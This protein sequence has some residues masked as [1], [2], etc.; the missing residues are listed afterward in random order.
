MLAA[1]P[2]PDPTE[3]SDAERV[4]DRLDP[5]SARI[6]RAIGL[7][8][9]SIAETSAALEHVGD[10]GAGGAAPGA[11]EARAAAREDG[12]MRTEQL[13]QAM[14]A[15]TERAAAAEARLPAALALATAAAGGLFLLLAGARPDLAEALGRLPVIV[16]Q[17]FPP[18]LAVGAFGA[19]LR[20]AR[21]GARVGGWA[22]A[23]LAVPV[24]LAAAV[25]ASSRRMPPAGWGAAMIGHSRNDCLVA[26]PLMSMPGLARRAVGAA[27]RGEHAARAHRGDGGPDERRGGGV[28]L[29]LLLQRRQSAFLGV[30]YVLAIL[31]VAG[32]GAVLGRLVL[33]W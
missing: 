5:R 14:A 10:G 24:L 17:L 26:I 9:A 19:A 29:R 20:L 31:I 2:E 22:L 23:L 7:E 15:D 18:L 12:G 8:G 32:A 25:I 33:R 21:P 11:E 6:V 28:A 27:P 16:K 4:I 1:E 3:R 30:W 13:I